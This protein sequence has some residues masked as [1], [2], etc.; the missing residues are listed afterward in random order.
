M[1]GASVVF[2]ALCVAGALAEHSAVTTAVLAVMAVSEVV[3]IRRVLRIEKHG[4]EQAAETGLG[5]R[6]QP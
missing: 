1:V 2:L 3:V 5:S 4:L 6:R